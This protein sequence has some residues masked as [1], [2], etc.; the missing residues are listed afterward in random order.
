MMSRLCRGWGRGTAAAEV[1]V[2]NGTPHAVPGL[3]G[4]RKTL[5]PDDAVDLSR[6]MVR[7]RWYLLLIATP[8]LGGRCDDEIQH[9]GQSF[10]VY[11]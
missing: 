4:R 11:P 1:T 9:M 3:F 6:A 10:W 5:A 8:R 2:P 7:S